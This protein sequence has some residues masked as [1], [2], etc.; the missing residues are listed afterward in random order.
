MSN[1]KKVIVKVQVS[2]A[3]NE[4]PQVLI[5][6]KG[7][8]QMWQGEVSSEIREQMR[9][10]A[11]AFFYAETGLDGYLGLTKEEAPWQQW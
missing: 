11:K 2:V 5:Y 3:G 4:G 10:R 9:G 1:R 8:A 7:R 6:T